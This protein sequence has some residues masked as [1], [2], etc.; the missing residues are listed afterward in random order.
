MD[1]WYYFLFGDDDIPARG[2]MDSKGGS[3]VEIANDGGSLK[4]VS[5]RVLMVDLA[6]KGESI[7]KEMFDKAIERLKAKKTP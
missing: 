3:T 2:R 5:G 6:H 4:D 1:T 7:T